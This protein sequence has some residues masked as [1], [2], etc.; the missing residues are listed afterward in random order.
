MGQEKTRRR[1][2]PSLTDDVKAAIQRPEHG[3]ECQQEACRR[4]LDAATSLVLHP[5][6]PAK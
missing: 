3:R 4:D 5:D 1:H 6:V 2:G